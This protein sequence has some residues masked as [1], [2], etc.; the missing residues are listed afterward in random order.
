MGRPFKPSRVI[1]VSDL[2]RT[3]SAKIMRRAVRA[4]AV[5][6]DPGN[7]SGAEN[8][9]ALDVLRDALAVEA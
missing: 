8:P 9:Q 1:R 2:P 5:G 6:E 4:V 3:R 7:L